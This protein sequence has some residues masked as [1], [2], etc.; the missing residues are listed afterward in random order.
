[1]IGSNLAKPAPRSLLN[2]PPG[3]HRRLSI[4]RVALEDVR[5]VKDTFKT[6]VND[7]VLAVTADAIGRFLRERTAR[8]D[9]LW[10]RAMVPVSTRVDS[11][12]T[13]SATGS[14]RCSP[15]CRCS[16]WTRSSGSG[17]ARTA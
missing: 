17:S 13:S 9:G 6:T 3:P 5:L 15:T 10:L 11:E 2:Q 16:R 4:Q 8:T 1:V 14:S 7:V 12:A